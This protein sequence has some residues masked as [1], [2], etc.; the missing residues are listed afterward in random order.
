MKCVTHA[1]LLFFGVLLRAIT[2]D[3]T[4][5]N[6]IF[7]PGAARGPTHLASFFAVHYNFLAKRLIAHGHESGLRHVRHTRDN[8]SGFTNHVVSFA[9]SDIPVVSHFNH[10]DESMIEVVMAMMKDLW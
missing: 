3:A 5:A 1:I 6:Y 4:L 7:F 2:I 10:E 9:A 8:R